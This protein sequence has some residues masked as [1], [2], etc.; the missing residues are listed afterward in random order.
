V[1]AQ[2]PNRFTPTGALSMPRAFPLAANMPDGTV[3]VVG[4]GPGAE[5]YQR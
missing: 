5:I 2:A 4:G 1:F 3:M